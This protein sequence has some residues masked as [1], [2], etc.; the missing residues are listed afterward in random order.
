V[1]SDTYDRLRYMDRDLMYRLN[2][3]GAITLDE[4]VP[5][6]IVR[7]DVPAEQWL[8]REQRR[9]RAKEA[10]RAKKR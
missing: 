1:N 8:N 4:T 3:T 6:G 5:D 2:E 9:A 10:R 7:E